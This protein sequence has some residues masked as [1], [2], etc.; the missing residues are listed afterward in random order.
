MVFAE[1]INISVAMLD[2]IV[3]LGIVRVQE[4]VNMC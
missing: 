3:A 4:F 1:A 2:N